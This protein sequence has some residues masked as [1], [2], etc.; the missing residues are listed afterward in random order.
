VRILPDTSIWIEYFRGH[1]AA[2]RLDRLLQ[3]DTVLSCGPVVAELLA[4]TAPA[5]QP[6]LWLAIG[7]LEL[8]ELD[9]AAWR[10]AGEHARALRERGAVVPLIDLLVAVAAIRSGAAL[11]TRD[12]DFERIAE[13]LPRLVLY[14]PLA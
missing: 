2:A 1:G 11:W 8:V 12:A 5:E 14:E 6:A 10:E 7:S 3:Q 9:V 4:G 13:L